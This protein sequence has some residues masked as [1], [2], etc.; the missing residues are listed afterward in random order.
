MPGGMEPSGMASIEPLKLLPECDEVAAVRGRLLRRLVIAL[1]S[2]IA[3][4]AILALAGWYVQSDRLVQVVPGWAPMHFNTAVTFLVTAAALILGTSSRW[5]W[6]PLLGV[7]A[8]AMGAAVIAEEVVGLNFGIDEAL[9]KHPIPVDGSHPGRMPIATALFFVLAG[10]ALVL[11]RRLPAVRWQLNTLS[12]LGGATLAG[13]VT[14]VLTCLVDLEVHQVWRELTS[15]SLPA[16]ICFLLLGGGLILMTRILALESGLDWRYTVPVATCFGGGLLSIAMSQVAFMHEERLLKM[17]FEADAIEIVQSIERE[18]VSSLEDLRFTAAFFAG[19]DHV[20]EDGFQTFVSFAVPRHNSIRALEWLPRVPDSM[21]KEFEAE[22][23]V[24]GHSGYAIRQLD[25]QGDLVP[26]ARREEYFPIRYVEPRDSNHSQLGFDHAS[27]ALRWQAM[28]EARD[29]GKA[30]T[31]R[32]IDRLLKR[33]MDDRPLGFFTFLPIY[34]QGAPVTSVE[35]R[36]EQLLG[37]VSGVFIIPEIVEAALSQFHAEGMHLHISGGTVGSARDVVYLLGT[38]LRRVVL[39]TST[40][41][42]LEE[43]RG[44]VYHSILHAGGQEWKLLCVP[45]PSYIKSHGSQAYIW[46]L[47][48]GFLFTGLVLMNVLRLSGRVA[49]DERLVAQRTR[50]LRH[51]YAGLE[52]EILQRQQNELMIGAKNR[53]LETLLH[54]TSHDLKEPL[55]GIENFSRLV[56]DRYAAVVDEK[57]R[58]FLRRIVAATER[59]TRLL[60]EILMLS[61][62]QRAERPDSY[63]N[64]VQLVR[65]AMARLEDRVQQT[66]ARVTIETDLPALRV[67]RTWAMQAIYNLLVNALKFTKEGE[68]P[69]ITIA[70]YRPRPGEG[71]VHG[72]KVLDRG[73]GVPPEYSDRIFQLFQRAVGRDVEGTGAGLAIVR[74]VAER[75]GGSARVEPRE[76]GGSVFIITFEASLAPGPA[77]VSVSPDAGQNPAREEPVLQA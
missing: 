21:R 34:R 58:D 28:V 33:G 36:R 63:I 12:I 41:E 14:A 46:I 73:P 71:N 27:E 62:A 18:V 45:T 37:F 55:R 15:M 40:E 77:A 25:A 1:G 26:A 9:F 75:H 24:G 39:E 30:V 76:G 44:L 51:A 31:L 7:L 65:E 52:R 50:E 49:R 47:T 32:R 5:R 13:G 29:S 8:G 2:S 59:M 4:I 61:R 74:Q 20:T 19:S 57:G 42:R 23:E 66:R 43:S 68:A 56:L 67:N 53:D 11:L 16:G 70:A 22:A 48:T 35:E 60:D 72:L 64:G 10:L 54:V 6:V 38:P 3:G 69:D 17:S